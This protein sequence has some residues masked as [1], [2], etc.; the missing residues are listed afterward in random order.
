MSRAEV[1]HTGRYMLGYKCFAVVRSLDCTVHSFAARIVD[2][3]LQTAAVVAGH[4]IARIVTGHNSHIAD[5]VVPVE[6]SALQAG[7]YLLRV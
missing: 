1:E 6:N 3:H 7:R 4:S 2:R 5:T